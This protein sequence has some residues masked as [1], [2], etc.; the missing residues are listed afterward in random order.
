[1]EGPRLTYPR[2]T[3]VETEAELSMFNMFGQ[4][5]APTGQKMLD[6]SAAFSGP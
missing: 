6:Y 1:L 3:L 4:A 2:I 5:G